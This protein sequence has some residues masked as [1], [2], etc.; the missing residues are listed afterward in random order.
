[1]S[2]LIPS[3]SLVSMSNII[4]AVVE[5]KNCRLL[6]SY[7]SCVSQCRG[8]Q[9]RPKL[10]TGLLSRAYVI[11]SLLSKVNGLSGNKVWALRLLICRAT[12]LFR[13]MAT[14]CRQFVNAEKL[15]DLLTLVTDRC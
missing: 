8:V 9:T 13:S 12:F 3:L 15:F 5:S 14:M 10:W 2:P 11:R 4:S 1:M 7:R 6:L